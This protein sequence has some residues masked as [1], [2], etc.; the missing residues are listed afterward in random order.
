MPA[1]ETTQLRTRAVYDLSGGMVTNYS[2]SKVAINQL[3]LILNG[4]MSTDGS[5]VTRYGRSKVNA[6][7]YGGGLSRIS[8]LMS[9]G[10]STGADIILVGLSAVASGDLIT[11]D[12]TVLRTLG[13]DPLLGSIMN[14]YAFMVNGTDTPFITDGT[15]AETYD[16]GIVTPPSATGAWG[17]DF[18][19]ID[20]TAVST[21]G[22][23]FIYARYRSTITGARSVPQVTPNWTF[24]G[25][26]GAP[27]FLTADKYVITVLEVSTDPQVDIIDYFVTESVGP[28]PP[29]VI[30]TYND[31]PA[32]FLGSIANTLG[33][34]ET[35]DVS[36]AEL[37]VKELLD[38]DDNSA[39]ATLKDIENFKGRMVGI[40]GDYTIQYS[41]RRVDANGVINLPTSW[42]ATNEA[43]IGWGDGDPLVKVVRAND[44][45][46][47]FK[48]RSVWLM[49][50]DFDSANFD[51]R[52]LKTNYTNVGLLNN[53]CVVQAGDS[54]FFISDDLKMYQFKMTDFSMSEL[55]LQQP[56][57]SDR[58]ANLFLTMASAYREYVNMVNYTFADY[59]QIWISFTDGT[60]GTVANDN[61]S[62]FVYDYNAGGGTG[63]WHVHTGHEVAS[64]VLAKDAN[65]D[66]NVYTGDYQGFLWKHDVSLGDGA[67]LNF[68]GEV[69]AGVLDRVINTDS[70]ANPFTSS[71]TGC[72]VRAV[73]NS[74]DANINQVRRGTYVDAATMTVSPSWSIAGS[75]NFTVGGIDFQVQSRDDW[76][77]DEAPLDYDKQGWYLDV[78]ISSEG[79]YGVGAPVISD[80][81]INVYKNRTD[82]SVTYNKTFTFVGAEWLYSYWGVD[83][84]PEPS[85]Y[86]IQVG[87]NMFFRQVSHRIISQLAGQRLRVNGWTYHYQQLGKL[88][89]R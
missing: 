42:P 78:D 85:N 49:L 31:E 71:M 79:L 12:G 44:F 88:R 59:A 19:T 29:V 69:Q 5:I 86:G 51:F 38:F 81:D 48:K 70:V 76:L 53:R 58:I 52:Q 30:P 66:Y 18:H 47:A 64:S 3:K 60:T 62:T 34:S 39:P 87:L 65:N 9:L 36:D 37:I 16:M 27:L 28:I 50:G 57:P 32:Y 46:F 80:L 7:I 84:W 63:A 23:H 82:N 35:F 75:G 13:E 17:M 10:Q 14:D 74:A 21:G 41:K 61:F 20:P 33:A 43:N 45:L 68:T 11:S 22:Y 26:T 73:S 4:D 56:P 83:I 6:T 77:D 1:D 72:L 55:R 40:T 89:V 67:A 24:I 15:V 2:Y 25:A 8:S 54:I